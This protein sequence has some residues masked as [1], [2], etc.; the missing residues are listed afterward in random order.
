MHDGTITSI[1]GTDPL[2]VR[3]EAELKFKKE[4]GEGWAYSWL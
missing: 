3:T 1:K 4:R 2:A